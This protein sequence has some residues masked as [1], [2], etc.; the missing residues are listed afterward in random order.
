MSKKFQAEMWNDAR[1]L[2][3]ATVPKEVF[4]NAMNK[5][6]EN[7]NHA[8]GELGTNYENVISLGNVS[9]KLVDWS[10]TDNESG[11]QVIGNFETFDTPCG[12]LLNTL[13]DSGKAFKVVPRG[14]GV[15]S[16]NTSSA[17]G[18]LE[19]VQLDLICFDIVPDS[20]VV[21]KE[22]GE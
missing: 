21:N 16:D 15:I 22:S 9:H 2:S 8:F 3:G 12:C 19:V 10:V 18:A 11:Y 4:V 1:K 13:I 20:A 5:Y 14:V 17:D 6:W 7:P